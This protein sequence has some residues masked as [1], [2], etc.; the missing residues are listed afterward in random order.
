MKSNEA[1]NRN[2]AEAAA[3]ATMMH[4]PEFRRKYI[5]QVPTWPPRESGSP[6]ALLFFILL[7]CAAREQVQLRRRHHALVRGKEREDARAHT[8]SREQRCAGK[9]VDS[10]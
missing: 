6:V 7:F 10:R 8:S 2:E 4:C 9:D 3:A 1:R 5:H